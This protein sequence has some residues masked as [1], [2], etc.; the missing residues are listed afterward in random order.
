MRISV[1]EW[2]SELSPSLWDGE[3]VGYFFLLAVC[4]LHFGATVDVT[5]AFRFFDGVFAPSE[6]PSLAASFLV[7][8]KVVFYQELTV[9]KV[10]ITCKCDGFSLV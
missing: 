10:R 6:G 1:S 5:V 3:G 9:L 8:L 2:D 4:F 7:P